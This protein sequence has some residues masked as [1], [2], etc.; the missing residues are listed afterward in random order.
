MSIVIIRINRN[1]SLQ[2][3]NKKISLPFKDKAKQSITKYRTETVL[4]RKMHSNQ[5]LA[6]NKKISVTFKYKAK[7]S[8]T[9]YR[10]EIVL[11]SQMSTV[12]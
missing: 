12:R 6:K 7:Q 10:T 2:S 11:N 9:K 5:W 8:I 1:D 3:K 4:D